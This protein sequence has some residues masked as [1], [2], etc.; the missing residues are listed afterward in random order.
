MPAHKSHRIPLTLYSIRRRACSALI[1][2]FPLPHHMPT[3]QIRIEE[4]RH[5]QQSDFYRRRRPFWKYFCEDSDRHIC[6]ALAPVG[7][8]EQHC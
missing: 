1:V 7:E 4:R 5:P 2:L 8:C 3:W 6:C